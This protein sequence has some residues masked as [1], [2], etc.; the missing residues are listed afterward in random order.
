M[1]SFVFRLAVNNF[2]KEAFTAELDFV[3][4]SEESLRKALNMKK[5]DRKKKKMVALPVRIVE[6]IT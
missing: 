3:A 4:D 6:Y 2:Q 5:W 1:K